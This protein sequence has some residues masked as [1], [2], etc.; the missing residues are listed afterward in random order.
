M[1][2][3]YTPFAD[4][5]EMEQTIQ[6]E[7]DV[8][9]STELF[10]NY[11]PF[12]NETESETIA[13]G[14]WESSP[15]EMEYFDTLHELH[16]NE[17]E[18]A[19]D[20]MIAEMQEQFTSYE[21]AGSFL[22]ENHTQQLAANYLQ[23]IV[24]ETH[25][26]FE[27]L[28]NELEAMPLQ[29]LSEQEFENSIDSIGLKHSE[30]FTPAQEFFFKKLGNKIKT[31]A[32]KVIKVAGKLSPTHLIIKKLKGVVGPLI[33]RILSKALNK[34]PASIRDIAMELANKLFKGKININNNADSDND[35][36]SEEDNAG[37]EDSLIGAEG[38]T[39]TVYPTQ[40]IQAEFDHYLA[41]FLQNDNEASQ[42]NLLAEYEN[43]VEG[44][45]ENELESIETA[46]ENFINELSNLKEG[47]D[48]TPALENFLPVVM[49]VAMKVLKVAVNLI[50]REKLVNLL[51][52]LIAKWIQK[53]L[54]PEKAQKLAVVMAD[55]GLKLLKLETAENENDAKAV[56]EAIANTVQEVATKVG[57]FSEEVFTNQELFAHEAYQAFENAA[58]AYFP[59]NAIKYEARESETENGYWTK[60]GRYSKF[61]KV[62][63]VTLDNNQLKSIIT[64]G[65]ANL[66]GF[67]KDTL[68]LPTNKPISAKVHIFQ[69]HYGANLSSITLNEKSIPNLGNSNRASYNQIHPLTTQ[70]AT[71][72]LGQPNLGRNVKS[73]AN[74]NRNLIFINE[75]FYFLQIQGAAAI[76]TTSND[77]I[78]NSN[79]V[80][81]GNSVG[82]DINPVQKSTQMKTVISGSFSQGIVFKSIIYFSENDSRIILEGLKK[83]SFGELYNYIKKLNPGLEKNFFG[84]NQKNG[85]IILK[86]IFEMAGNLV[87]ENLAKVVL[88]KIKQLINQ[89]EKAVQDPKNGVTLILQFTFPITRHKNLKVRFKEAFESGTLVIVPGFATK[90][91][92]VHIPISNGVP[93]N[94]NSAANKTFYAAITPIDVSVLR[95]N[96]PSFN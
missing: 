93:F 95:V 3:K 79:P 75:R 91:M 36:A 67:A 64:F 70:A 32:K 53:F 8:T 1:N 65:G 60:K 20:N 7:V 10:A 11:S 81:I 69:A 50:G 18:T 73:I 51:A 89:F 40:N 56:Y 94:T 42:N 12:S 16:D 74:R 14:E 44:E 31:I 52:G 19:V 57:G 37:T 84:S 46:R 28:A 48:P 45:Q 68:G 78:P 2:T 77:T 13:N 34:L 29:Q 87:K 41:N 33:K 30:N 21:S 49:K 88:D 39:P 17:F 82:V 62:F 55:K 66:L 15:N 4:E 92:P 27:L 80:Q 63:D 47:E 72:L 76:S 38:E 71:V 83:Q 5:F 86:G 22:N 85:G 6:Q 90:S 23:P 9:K 61:T 96:K 25:Q 59:D 54:D 58:A 43:R 24:N 26:L 35:N